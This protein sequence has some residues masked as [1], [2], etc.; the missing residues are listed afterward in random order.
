MDA[1]TGLERRKKVE[2]RKLE[3]IKAYK[4]VF[5]SDEGQKVLHDIVFSACKV[6]LP[7]QAGQDIGSIMYREGQRS[8]GLALLKML[9]KDEDSII[10]FIRGATIKNQI[11]TRELNDFVMGDS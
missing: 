10:K 2:A 3:L 6:D 9:D 4:A 8:I 5:G 1:Q 11:A 7:A